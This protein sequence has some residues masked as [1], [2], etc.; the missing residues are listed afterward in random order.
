MTRAPY[1]W[2]TTSPQVYVRRPIEQKL[3]DA[4]ARGDGGVL[5]GGRGMGKSVL[6][7]RLRQR[8]EAAGARVVFLRNPPASTSDGSI[9]RQIQAE[10]G[11][12]PE[13]P[14]FERE[15][16]DV[17]S[18]N[19]NHQAVILYDDY[20]RFVDGTRLLD[21]LETVRRDL[22][23]KLPIL[24]AGPPKL[25][26]T[27]QSLLGSPFLS[28]CTWHELEPF[29]RDELTELARS[30]AERNTPLPEESLDALLVASGGIPSIVLYG[31][32]R[33]WTVERPDL[34][35]IARVM[36]EFAIEHREFLVALV[37]QIGGVESLSPART[38]WERLSTGHELVGETTIRELVAATDSLD[39][40]DVFQAKQ[41]L[42]VGG[43]V[44]E[45]G[46]GEQ[47][48]LH[49]TS[50]LAQL[51]ALMD[52]SP[53]AKALDLDQRLVE[54]VSEILRC[55]RSLSPD[56]F[57]SGKEILPEAVFS[58]LMAISLR[59]LGWTAEREVLQSAG[60]TDIKLT[61][62][63]EQG[64][65]VIEVKI[66]PRNDYSQIH[67]QVNAYATSETKARVAVMIANGGVAA[68][69]YRTTC[70]TQVNVVEQSP[71]DGNSIHF[72]AMRESVTTHH[73]LIN[74]ASRHPV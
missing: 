50:L 55:I 20:D 32:Q 19:G 9:R 22:S 29:G 2:V 73:F 54:R 39:R 11:V 12:D 62:P 14:A 31:L 40:I 8:A 38:L 1:D 61:L 26:G 63:S 34:Q 33:L 44:Q 46:T 60:R 6:L 28:R 35:D 13:S 15:L 5:L 43:L 27:S 45:S 58:A 56:F 70:L 41:V 10:L 42:K 4:L 3:W 59:M 69:T 48:V 52:G 16:L 74:L 64:N 18:Q 51:S 25:I 36:S 21:F 24:V 53:R 66:W 23:P 47:L 57:R 49:P 17:L 68:E 37:R 72:V 71:L 7:R 30:F 67:T 65:A